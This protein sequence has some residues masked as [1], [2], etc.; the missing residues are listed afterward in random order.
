MNAIL[1]FLAQ[2]LLQALAVMTVVSFLSFG[3]FQYVGDPV[4]TVLGAD[5][6]PEQIQD[7]RTSLGLNQPV[8]LQFAHFVKNAVQ[9][10][11][12][13][14]L[15]QGRPVSV[16]IAERFPATMELALS[17]SVVALVLGV[18]IGVLVA[19]CEEVLTRPILTR[20]IQPKTQLLR[21]CIQ[22]VSK[23][24]MTGSLLGISL[25]PFLI[26]I[27][28]IFI[29]SVQTGGFLPSHERG[30]VVLLPWGWTTGF[31]SVSGW[32]HLILPTITLAVFQLALLARLV[33]AEMRWVLRSDFIRFARARGLAPW[34]IY[35]GHALKNIW[36]PVLTVLGLQLGSLV[37]FSIITEPVF[38]WPGLGLLLI[39]A[40]GKSD[41]NIMAAYLCM[42][43]LVFVS[44][45]ALVDLLY[46]LVDPRLR[47]A[48]CSQGSVP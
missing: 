8:W 3:I 33:R 30:D 36:L 20:P 13:M 37:A 32:R 21:V 22:G 15:S 34:R 23:I 16:L 11:F 46:L 19:L 27:I 48:P 26:G 28:L 14:S 4:R 17:A 45:N 43:A 5:A 29:F 39:Q 42:V 18:G 31:L 2:R 40:I 1:V 9:G 6:T 24:L 10:N 44:I 47:V 38:E 12:G 25:P 7:V 35:L 41:V